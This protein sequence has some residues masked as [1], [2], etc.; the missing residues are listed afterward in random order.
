[1][2]LERIER[3]LSVGAYEFVR[4]QLVRENNHADVDA[5]RRKDIQAAD[6]G[7]LSGGVAV[8][9]NVH[10]LGEPLEQPRLLNRKRGSQTRHS[11]GNPRL[12]QA[13][14][15]RISFNNHQILTALSLLEVQPVKVVALVVD[16]RIARVDIL[17]LI[18]VQHAGAKPE[19]TPVRADDRKDHTVPI[20]IVHG[21]PVRIMHK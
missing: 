11:V 1:M 14:Y 17:G 8:V 16:R 18:V 2:L 20:S 13:D 21:V 15:I 6:G 3:I 10:Q 19:D 9:G 4:I 5:L 7:V 12:E